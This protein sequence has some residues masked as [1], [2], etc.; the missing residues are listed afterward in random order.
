[1][2]IV[3]RLKNFKYHRHKY[4]VFLEET[5]PKLVHDSFAGMRAKTDLI[6][7]GI[8]KRLHMAVAGQSVE[9]LV[10]DLLAEVLDADAVLF[11]QIFGMRDR[12]LTS[13]DSQLDRKNAK[14][15]QVVEERE[16]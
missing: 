15:S 8:Y 9:R 14:R 6:W 7:D 4:V 1:M 5:F 11:H 3:F 13:G 10:Q 2:E 12:I 16:I